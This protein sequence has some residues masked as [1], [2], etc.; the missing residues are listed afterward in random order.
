MNVVVVII[1]SL[2]KDHV[3]AYGNDW[4]HTPNL[5][6]LAEDSLRFNRAYPDS[7]PTICARRAIHTGIRTWPFRNWDPPGDEFVGVYGWQPIPQDQTTIAQIMRGQDYQTL[8]VTDTY[9]QFKPYYDF[10][11]GFDVFD[12]VRGQENDL[13]KPLSLAP[14]NKLKRSLTGGPKREHMQ[15][16]LRQYLANTMTR[17]TEEDWFTPQVFTRAG[18][19]LGGINEDSPPF[20]MVVDVYDPHEPWDPPEEYVR[21]YDEGY[22]STAP[23]TAPNS[24]SGW[25]SEQQLKRMRALYSGSV[26]MVDRW[27]GHFMDEMDSLGL[28]DNTMIMLL[29]DHGHA[30]GE[31]GYAGKVP[32]ALYPELTDIVFMI[33]DPRGKQAGKT[34]DYYASTHDVAPTILG[35]LGIALPEQMD[36]QDL[37]PLLEGRDP[38]PRPHFSFGYDDQV[39]TRDDEY[40]MISRNDNYGAE[41]YHLQSDPGMK[42]DLAKKDP[43]AVKRMFKEY[44]L[45]D[46]GGPLPNY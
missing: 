27:L 30:F 39:Y 28:M 37:T 19:L 18:E 1:D 45:K 3:G 14:K 33:R 8:L 24:T 10:H 12:F 41:L 43:E 26:T 35:A 20:F 5:D 7:L 40:A 42:K 29:S 17:K 6:A 38:A 15:R 31:H 36:G 32:E 44:V 11:R 46:A 34:S 21:L 4:I 13:Y 2:R 22:E 25:L 23:M 16:I 9:H